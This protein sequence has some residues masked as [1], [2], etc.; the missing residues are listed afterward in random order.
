MTG[1]IASLAGSGVITTY[2]RSLG[3]DFGGSSVG[4][5]RSTAY[6]WRDAT[7]VYLKAQRSNPIRNH[8]GRELQD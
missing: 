8:D 4:Q 6:D 5:P 7:K 2:I 3:E 1:M